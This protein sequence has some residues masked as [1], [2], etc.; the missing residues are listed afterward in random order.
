MVPGGGGCMQ[1]PKAHLPASGSSTNYWGSA[2][3]RL[4]KEQIAP[5]E[6]ANIDTGDFERKVTDPPPHTGVAKAMTNG[7]WDLGVDPRSRGLSLI[8][9]PRLPPNVLG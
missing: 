1:G 8:L 5:A 6:N 9:N 7:C 3:F 2:G 4:Q